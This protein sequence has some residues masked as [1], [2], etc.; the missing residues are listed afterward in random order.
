L[1]LEQIIV[2]ISL[3]TL[4]LGQ[5]DLLKLGQPDLLKIG[6]PHFLKP[7]TNDVIVNS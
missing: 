1:F 6:Q 4:K 3:L 7:H 5:P 2:L